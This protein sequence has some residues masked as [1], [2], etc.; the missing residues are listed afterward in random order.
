MTTFADIEKEGRLLY[1]YYR[2]SYA[3]STFIE[4]KSDMDE[5]GIYFNTLD[6]ILG[7]VPYEDEIR[8]ERG[9]TVW[10]SLKKYFE[11]LGKSNPSVL[12][13]LF[14]PERCVIYEHPLFAKLREKRHMFLSQE[15]FNSIYGYSVSQIRKARGLNKKIVNPIE[16]RLEPLD[17]AYVYV[18]ETFGTVP[19]KKWLN[20]HG[21]V[22]E[23]CGLVN[24]PNMYG[25]YS[26]YYDKDGSLNYRGMCSGLSNELRLSSIPKGES[27]ICVMSYSK[28]GYSSHCRQ[29]QEYQ[30][31]VHKRNPERYKENC[32]KDYDRKNIMHCMRLM[33]MGIEL[34]EMGELNI[35]RTDRDAEFLK[36]IRLGN[37]EYDEVMSLVMSK[38]EEMEKA[39]AKTTLRKVIDLHEM[40]KEF[41][42]LQK[43]LYHL[44]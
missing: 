21:Y 38:N 39:M 6:E 10:W 30:E 11:L 36:N 16:K 27:P 3:Y 24:L 7:V 23:H 34:A 1:R 19:A 32:E 15:C 41:I 37:M 29:W 33:S 9:D 2:G 8:D 25:M 35:D 31:W 5:G 42:L 14:V 13:S 18:P 22:Q 44:S 26:V 28:D 43:N 40:N 12:E 20:D 4:G 17:F